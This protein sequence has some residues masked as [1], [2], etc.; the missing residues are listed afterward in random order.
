MTTFLIDSNS[1]HLIADKLIGVRHVQCILCFFCLT[2]AYAMRVNLTVA[3]VAMRSPNET[4]TNLSNFNSS[5][6][7]ANLSALDSSAESSEIEDHDSSSSW[8]P[9]SVQVSSRHLLLIQT[10]TNPSPPFYS[11][12]TTREFKSH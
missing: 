11:S 4:A 10:V 2:L 6:S 5:S 3:I 12:I 9:F 1:L 7:A 8:N